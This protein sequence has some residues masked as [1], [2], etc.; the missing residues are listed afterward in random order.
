MNGEEMG[1]AGAGKAKL[2]S[3]PRGSK[4]LAW[5]VSRRNTGRSTSR[6]QAARESNIWQDPSNMAQ[7]WFRNGSM[8]FPLVGSN[9]RGFAAFQGAVMKLP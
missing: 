3:R 2:E 4:V 5:L 1:H 8:A 9:S 7:N 6:L